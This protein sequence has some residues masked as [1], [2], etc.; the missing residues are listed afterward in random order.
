MTANAALFEMNHPDGSECNGAQLAE[1]I[2]LSDLD[3]RGQQ[4]VITHCPVCGL[5]DVWRNAI[6]QVMRHHQYGLAPNGGGLDDQPAPFAAMLPPVRDWIR[7]REAA[8]MEA[9]P[10]GG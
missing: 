3:E 2:V 9:L 10:N 8:A 1:P 7:A 5:D 4:V 6:L